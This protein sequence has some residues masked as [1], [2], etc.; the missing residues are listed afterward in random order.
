MLDID[1]QT[2]AGAPLGSSNFGDV[3]PGTTS[4]PLPLKLVNT[5]TV[6]HARILCW[7]EQADTTDGAMRAVIGGVAITGTSRETATS[8]PGL[9][10]A[11][12]VPGEVT[13]YNP[14]GSP[15]LPVDTGVL[16]VR[17]E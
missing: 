5:G 17:V 7:I 9:A 3:P 15:G 11:G 16:R 13:W 14:A 12:S 2:P 1:I 6:A 8:L 10:P 4:N